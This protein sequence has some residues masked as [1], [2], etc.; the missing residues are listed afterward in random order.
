MSPLATAAL[1]ARSNAGSSLSAMS[2]I[3]L[4]VFGVLALAVSA[5]TKLPFYPVPLTLQTLVV[6]VI[7]MSY[8][9]RLGGVTI[10]S[11]LSIGALGA[12]VFAGGAGIVYFAGIAV[13]AGWSKKWC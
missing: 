8:G 1:M 3:L 7:G 9:M 5:N 11:Y 12:P 4:L 10:L 2:S 13:H 6:M